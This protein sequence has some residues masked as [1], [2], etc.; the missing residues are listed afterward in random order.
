MLKGNDCPYKSQLKHRTAQSLIT[1]LPLATRNSIT[2]QDFLFTNQWLAGCI[3]SLD[4]MSKATG[5]NLFRS[6]F[7]KGPDYFH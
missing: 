5:W 7:W 3:A 4:S 2:S 6:V 1:C